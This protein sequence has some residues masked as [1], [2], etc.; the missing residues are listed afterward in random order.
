MMCITSTGASV[1]P[2][3]VNVWATRRTAT[4]AQCLPPL[5]AVLD[6]GLHGQVQRIEKYTGGNLEAEAV[7]LALVAEVLGLTTCKTGFCHKGM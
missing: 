2:S 3:S 5:L 6:P 7:M 4:P 1:G